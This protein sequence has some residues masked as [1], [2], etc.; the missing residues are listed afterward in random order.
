MSRPPVKKPNTSTLVIVGIIV[1]ILIAAAIFAIHSL[2]TTLPPVTTTTS[3]PTNTS[4]GGSATDTTTDTATSTQS[5]G[6]ATGM[7]IASAPVGTCF[8][9]QA[10]IDS[11]GAYVAPIDCTEAHDSEVFYSGNVSETTYPD[12]DG[13]QQ[14]VLDTCHPAF[15]TYT[16]ITFGQN[17]WQIYYIYPSQ[18][19]WDNG[20]R[21]LLCYTTDPLQRTTSVKKAS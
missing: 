18:Q 4:Q 16:G 17:S 7:P 8:E 9:R 14:A 20:S 2:T 5:E 21:L 19:A 6:A 1:V 12:S 10:T 3:L 11:K 15:K 13:W